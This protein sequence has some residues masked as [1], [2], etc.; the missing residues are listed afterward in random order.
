MP[1]RKYASCYLQEAYNA[2][3][4]ILYI[5]LLL[6]L[7]SPFDCGYCKRKFKTLAHHSATDWVRLVHRSRVVEVVG[8][9]TAAAIIFGNAIGTVG[10]VGDDIFGKLER[11]VHIYI[12]VKN[13][14]HL[15]SFLFGKLMARIETS[16]GRYGEVFAT[17]TATRQTFDYARSPL[18]VYHK[19]EKVEPLV[20]LAPIDINLRQLVILLQ[21]AR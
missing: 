12:A 19:V 11:H 21:N 6:R 16:V 17:R 10:L 1:Q 13:V 2:K 5:D 8:Y 7:L 20:A 15:I 4:N 3:K 18:E 9:A 14:A